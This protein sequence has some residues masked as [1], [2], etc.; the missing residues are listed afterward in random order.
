MEYGA[1][2][3]LIEALEEHGW[4]E[5]QNLAIERY[6]AQG[7]PELLPALAQA[8]VNSGP[9]VIFSA[10]SRTADAV[11]AA[12]DTIP[13]VCVLGTRLIELHAESLAR[14]GGNLTGPAT[15]AGTGILAKRLQLLHEAVPTM[16]RVAWLINHNG[17]ERR[18]I[19]PQRRAFIE[20]ADQLGIEVLPW[21][22]DYPGEVDTFRR[23]FATLVDVPVD[24]LMV[25]GTVLSN[26]LKTL[27]VRLAIDAGLPSM[28]TGRR[29]Y[30]DFGGLMYFSPDRSRIWRRA[31]WYVDR[32][33]RGADPAELPIEQPTI[34]DF[35]IN[36]KTAKE[37]GIEFPL[38]ILYRAT[39]VIE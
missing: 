24:G 12:T 37:I 5:G 38:T 1:Y 26:D 32:I 29:E 10:A 33:F 8:V 28:R 14:P 17:W 30:I 31:A 36:L 27:I 15:N 13:V 9:D 2:G 21:L 4:V 18:N 39:E 34:Y 16:K 22:F 3:A 11:M 19:N 7:N 35:I 20:F 23:L 6:S 25:E